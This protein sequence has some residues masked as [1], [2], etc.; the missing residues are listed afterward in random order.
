LGWGNH[1]AVIITATRTNSYSKD[2]SYSSSEY[3]K[4][5]AYKI[6]ATSW[7]AINRIEKNASH[8]AAACVDSPVA[9]LKV[10]FWS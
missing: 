5:K 7:D 6:H 8:A 2:K 4:E 1:V 9:R 3:P 10:Q